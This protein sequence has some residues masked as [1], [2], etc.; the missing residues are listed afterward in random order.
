MA[1]KAGHAPRRLVHRGVVEAAGILVDEALVGPLEARR[2]VIAA[3]SPGASVHRLGAGLLV[4]FPQPR[5]IDCASAPGLPLVRTAASSTAPLASAPLAPDELA[6]VAPPAGS[7]VLVRAGALAAVVPAPADV[8]EPAHYLDLAD[9]TV[10]RVEPLGAPPAAPKIVAAPTNVAARALL[11][12]AAAPAEQS[13]VAAALAAIA[14]GRAPPASAAEGGASDGGGSAALSFFATIGAGIGALL[15]RLFGGSAPTGSAPS[16]S[17]PARGRS[18]GSHADG[19]GSALPFFTAIASVF[20]ALL[21]RLFTQPSAVPGLPGASSAQGRGLAAAPAEPA[22]P[23]LRDRLSARMRTW[24]AQLLVRARLAHLVGRRQAEYV[25]RLLDM[26]DRGDLDQA[27]RHAIPLGGSAEGP[28]SPALG[29]PAPRSD[30]SISLGSRGLGTAMAATTD[31]Y[32]HLRQ[33]YRAAFER[34]EREGRI[35]EAAFVLAELLQ[36]AA[37]AVSFLERHG[38]L[39][40]AAELAEAR[41]L[42][43]GLVVRQWFLA[44]DIGRAVRIARRHGA[45]ADALLRLDKHARAPELRVLWA[46]TLAEA[47]DFAAAVD[48]IWPIESARR[49]GA[50]WIDRAI[51]QGGASA[52]RML[53]KKLQLVP[54]S[55]PDV[56]EMVLALLAADGPQASAERR[57][58]AEALVLPTATPESRTLA[59]PVLRALTQDAARSADPGAQRVVSR[60]VEHAGDAALRADM[61]AWPT[62]TRPRLASVPAPHTL[63]IVATDSGSMPVLDAAHLPSG[64]LLVALGEAGVRVLGRDG[65]VLFHLDQPA[66]R[67]VVSDHGDRALAL[68]PRG[69]GTFRLARLDLVGRR[70]EVWCDATI[71]TFAPDF[72]GSQW[73]VGRD[74][75]LFLIDALESRFEALAELEPGG[76]VTAVGRSA[77]SCTVVVSGRD[78]LA[79]RVRYELPSWFMR[80]RKP[81]D[82]EAV[83]GQNPCRRRRLRDRGRLPRAIGGRGGR[84]AAPRAGKGRPQPAQHRAPLAE[85]RPRP[86]RLRAPGLGDRCSS[87]E[88]GRRGPPRRRRSPHHA[89]RHHPRRLHARGAAPVGRHADRRR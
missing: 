86:R 43:P 68:A 81:R 70:T 5:R 29:V 63:T 42:Q 17:A 3:W 25:G 2:R 11:G 64:R 77:A 80:A 26:L 14:A 56:R 30:L 58:F 36:E 69:R 1:A 62:I 76:V 85:G 38:R 78:D 12:V 15:G 45:F 52:A 31:L 89:L 57:A 44:G 82:L 60:L 41:K 67:L 72:D 83:R 32:A 75:R 47:G 61:P 65:R 73:V 49:V 74:D 40:L 23:S 8:E 66:H 35:D 71:G 88:F 22:G 27:L 51:A 46:E 55:F 53:A 7:I 24:M 9:F 6:A 21:R 28:V 48:V 33:K 54:E 10:V 20:G 18:A 79:T 39:R 13:A 16:G 59:R 50:A 84:A 19:G 37:E 34:L 87:N 4:R